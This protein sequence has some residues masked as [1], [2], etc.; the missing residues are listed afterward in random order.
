[1]NKPKLQQVSSYSQCYIVDKKVIDSNLD[2]KPNQVGFPSTVNFN[3][4]SSSLY[5][6]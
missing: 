5:L 4:F 1:M 2:A 6:Q 3:F